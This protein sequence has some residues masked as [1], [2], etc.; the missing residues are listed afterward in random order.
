MVECTNGIILH[1]MI[2]IMHHVVH[3]H[4][5]N[6]AFG[7]SSVSWTLRKPLLLILPHIGVDL[8]VLRS[9]PCQPSCFQTPLALFPL[10]FVPHVYAVLT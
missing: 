10:F 7:L 5:R 3:S 8:H 4:R 1:Y 6:I 2:T 9:T